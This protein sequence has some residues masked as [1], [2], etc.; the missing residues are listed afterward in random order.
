M[1]SGV[2][3]LATH[4]WSPDAARNAQ[5]LEWKYERNPYLR[6]PVLHVATLEGRPVAMRGMHGML[7]ECCVPART[8]PALYA[9]DLVVE[10]AH[11]SHGLVAPI[12]LAAARDARRRGIP[13][14]FNMSSSS[15][16]RMA[17]LATGWKSAGPAGLHT[18]RP[19]NTAAARNLRAR[20]RRNPLLGW[21]ARRVSYR[22]WAVRDVGAGEA[23]ARRRSRGR[24][25]G[26]AIAVETEPRP[27][28]MADL[29]ARLGHDGR[30]RHVRDEAYLS[31][32]YGNP[33]NR[34][35]FV[36]W[37]DTTLRGY[38]SLRKRVEAPG[39]ARTGFEISDWEAESPDIRAGLL[40]AALALCAPAELH[41]WT[42]TLPPDTVRILH[43][44]GFTPGHKVEGVA[45]SDDWILVQST[46]ETPS[47]SDWSR[48]GLPLLD[49]ASWDLRMIYSMHG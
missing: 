20:L 34:Y 26:D 29:V 5:L 45:G 24:A 39:P 6:E 23:L 33:L 44:A 27:A 7:L 11:R 22:P 36:L 13:H 10:P 12:L 49:L 42:A 2:A 47:R 9:D 4:L 30:I 40:R 17:S 8:F 21:I 41:A 28:E 18:W 38:L 48:G 35:L 43:D 1:K 3:R 46:A 15:V 31:W 37:R 14:V 25:A 16:T 32:R 19:A